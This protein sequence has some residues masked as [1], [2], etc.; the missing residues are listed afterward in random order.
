[1]KPEDALNPEDDIFFRKVGQAVR[2]V[3]S[4]HQLKLE[5]EIGSRRAVIDYDED[6]IIWVEIT[7]I[8]PKQPA[9]L[10]P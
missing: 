4:N 1:M 8:V 10:V 2:Q 7:E 5:I 6:D 9:L 3:E